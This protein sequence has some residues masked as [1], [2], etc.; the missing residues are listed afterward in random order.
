MRKLNYFIGALAMFSL[1]FLQASF[2]INSY[3]KTIW[4]D[5]FRILVGIGVG[6]GIAINIFHT[7]NIIKEDK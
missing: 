1:V 4:D 3:P 7:F 5:L 6:C 2:I